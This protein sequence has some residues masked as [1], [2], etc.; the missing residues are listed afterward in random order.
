MH[1][2]FNHVIGLMLSTCFSPFPLS[3]KDLILYVSKQDFFMLLFVVLPYLIYV[4]CDFSNIRR[5]ALPI[6]L[7][8][9]IYS[10]LCYMHAN[11]SCKYARM[12]SSYRV[13]LR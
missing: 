4:H 9:V 3:L 2:Y 5:C 7:F 1:E 12:H 6:H 10:C 13:M 11:L 8:I